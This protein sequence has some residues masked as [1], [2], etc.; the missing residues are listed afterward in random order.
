[1]D[2]G[3]LA[4]TTWCTARQAARR[5]TCT[6]GWRAGPPTSAPHPA[7]HQYHTTNN[8]L[9]SQCQLPRCGSCQLHSRTLSSSER[10]PPSLA[11]PIRSASGKGRALAERRHPQQ[12]PKDAAHL[13]PAADDLAHTDGEDERLAPASRRRGA[14]ALAG[15]CVGSHGALPC[16]R[17]AAP[18]A[19]CQQAGSAHAHQSIGPVNTDYS[20]RHAPGCHL[21]AQPRVSPVAGRVELLPVSQGAGV[22]DGHTVACAGGGPASESLARNAGGVWTLLLRCCGRSGGC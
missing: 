14:Q 18:A 5:P 10:P 20:N 22:M 2:C 6:P 12:R 21:L 17:L 1:M 8:I 15:P 3:S 11:R 19:S 13:V 16:H 9:F 7:P 4:R